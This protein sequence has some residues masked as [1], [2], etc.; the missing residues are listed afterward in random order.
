MDNTETT[1]KLNTGDLIALNIALAEALA[2]YTLRQVEGAHN[3]SNI[4]RTKRLYNETYNLLMPSE[5]GFAVS[6]T[7]SL[8]YRKEV[9][10]G[11]R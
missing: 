3:T 6:G 5:S 8:P 11:V 4:G 7:P 10:G 9:P 1:M 2:K